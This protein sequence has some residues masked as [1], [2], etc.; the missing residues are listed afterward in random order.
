MF[1]AS[2]RS[3]GNAGTQKGLK[4]NIA[5]FSITHLATMVYENLVKRLGMFT[6]M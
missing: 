6:G 4:G 1:G 3:V 2:P 5:K